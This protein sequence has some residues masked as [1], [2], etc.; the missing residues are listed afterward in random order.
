MNSSNMRLRSS[1]EVTA[2]ND[3]ESSSVGLSSS[4]SPGLLTLCRG[5]W[6]D[7]QF[8]MRE[9]IERAYERAS[10][11]AS[12]ALRARQEQSSNDSTRGSKGAGAKCVRRRCLTFFRSEWKS[13]AARLRSFCASDLRSPRMT[14][15]LASPTSAADVGRAEEGERWAL[16]KV[17]LWPPDGA[18][19]TCSEFH[20]HPQKDA[21]QPP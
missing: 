20:S 13:S 5:Q 15:R 2:V 11:F 18:A 21:Q 12:R 16:A 14:L 9:R 19:Q 7:R 6:K 1:S 10:E 3:L 8:E 17:S 4:Q